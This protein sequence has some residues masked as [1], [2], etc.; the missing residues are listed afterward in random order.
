MGESPVPGVYC[1]YDVQVVMWKR[2]IPL[3]SGSEP[4]FSCALTLSFGINKGINEPKNEEEDAVASFNCT[5]LRNVLN[6][7]PAE[8]MLVLDA[9]RASTLLGQTQPAEDLCSFLDK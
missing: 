1:A 2:Q 9:L 6:C 8:V 5:L 4:I 3:F 7:C